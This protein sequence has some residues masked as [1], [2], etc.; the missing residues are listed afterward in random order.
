MIIYLLP[1]S[2]VFVALR[3][4]RFTYIVDLNNSPLCAD[5]RLMVQS[6]RIYVMALYQKMVCLQV[7]YIMSIAQSQFTL[8]SWFI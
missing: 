3:V 4:L 8:Y 6:R 7:G 2:G 1:I 5:T